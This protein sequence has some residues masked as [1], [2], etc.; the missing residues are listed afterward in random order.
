MIEVVL[1]S[2]ATIVE[3]SY[4]FISGITENHCAQ[5]RNA[6]PYY[7]AYDGRSKPINFPIPASMHEYKS[8]APIT[9]DKKALGEKPDIHEG[10][11]SELL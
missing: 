8:D 1:H 7:D 2:N 3:L 9:L 5:Y 4:G 10:L 11:D 6:R